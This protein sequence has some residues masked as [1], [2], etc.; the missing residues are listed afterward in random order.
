MARTR[1][2]RRLLVGSKSTLTI[3]HEESAPLTTSSI[4]TQ[5]GPATLSTVL[6]SL[7][8]LLLQC[9]AKRIRGSS[10]RQIPQASPRIFESI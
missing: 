3:S 5:Q 4:M 10:Q 1:Q 7:E 9:L 2:Q 8:Q 6:L